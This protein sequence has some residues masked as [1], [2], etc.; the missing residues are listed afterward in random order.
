M[1]GL[2]LICIKYV[3]K[4][5]FAGEASEASEGC[6]A[7]CSAWPATTKKR[8]STYNMFRLFRGVSGRL[9][10]RK[11]EMRK[12]LR[13]L[14][15]P[16]ALCLLNSERTA[17]NAELHDLRRRAT[18]RTAQADCLE[19]RVEATLPCRFRCSCRPQPR[20]AASR[21]RSCQ[22]NSHGAAPR[23]AGS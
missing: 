4:C 17:L 18:W 22:R 8:S 12:K 7:I 3:I 15:A 5:I 21:H 11:R 14:R 16:A 23:R 2:F 13:S 1:A 6:E 9:T 10:L 20:R 19:G